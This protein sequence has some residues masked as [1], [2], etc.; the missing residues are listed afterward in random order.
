MG[1]LERL[2]LRESEPRSEEEVRVEKIRILERE[3]HA[4]KERAPVE[5]HHTLSC[6]HRSTRPVRPGVP[7]APAATCPLCAM[8]AIAAREGGKAPFRVEDELL[9]V[10]AVKGR[11]DSRDIDRWPVEWQESYAEWLRERIERGEL[12]TPE[13]EGKALRRIEELRA[14]EAEQ[15]RLDA[16]SP[17]EKAELAERN[18]RKRR[19]VRGG[20]I[21]TYRPSPARSGR[22]F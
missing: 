21:G 9:L 8:E 3:Y 13:A 12:L 1:L 7:T 5:A 6:G 18:Y 10:D 20:N 16:L 15:E 4:S 14:R 11:V 22:G 19:G 17:V 2:G